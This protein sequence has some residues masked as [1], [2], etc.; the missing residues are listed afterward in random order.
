MEDLVDKVRTIMRARTTRDV[1]LHRLLA[2]A[3]DIETLTLRG[4]LILEELMMDA[5]ASHCGNPSH[6][7]D[8]R[9]RFPQL[10]CLVRAV[11]VTGGVPDSAWLAIGRF[12]TLRNALAH[13]LEVAD[14][15]SKV[16]AIVEAVSGAVP[17]LTFPRAR[18]SV[19]SLRRAIKALFGLLSG[20]AVLQAGVVAA[21]KHRSKHLLAD[22]P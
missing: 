21:V 2:S 20:V 22:A 19:S 13:R 12:N 15:E 1:E 17:G 10:V 14:A 6:L 18:G 4:H 7:R 3:K 9:L 8:A 16:A 5:L 11:E